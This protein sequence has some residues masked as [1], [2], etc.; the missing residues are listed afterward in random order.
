[1]CWVVE[2]FANTFLFTINVSH[3][4]FINWFCEFFLNL[5]NTKSCST[6]ILFVKAKK[7]AIFVCHFWQIM[8]LNY[9]ILVSIFRGL[10]STSN[11]KPIMPSQFHTFC[12]YGIYI[13]SKL[14]KIEAFIIDLLRH[15]WNACMIEYASLANNRFIRHYFMEFHF[16]FH[17][18]SKNQ[19]Q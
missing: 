6:M 2:Y 19:I 7:I 9:L 15:L 5:H 18:H 10:S 12:F 8:P 1:M 4:V 14:F 17:E 3:L 13:N 11:L 16:R